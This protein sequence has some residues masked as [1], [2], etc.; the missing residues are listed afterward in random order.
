MRFFD[1]QQ[2]LIHNKSMHKEKAFVALKHQEKSA[3]VS[4][5][6]HDLKTLGLASGESTRTPYHFYAPNVIKRR[7]PNTYSHRC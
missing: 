3:Q 7:R 1:E 4:Q 6:W 5:H 2:A